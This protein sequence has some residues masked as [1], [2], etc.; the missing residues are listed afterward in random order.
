MSAIFAAGENP[1]SFL[2]QFGI[3]WQLL[4][5]QGVSFAIVAAALYRFVFKPVIAASNERKQKIE[6]GLKD[7]EEAKSKL[8]AAQAEAE[9][10]SAEAA[11]EAAKILKAARD[12]AKET[13]ERAAR[14][15][16]AKAAEIRER[17][18]RQLERDKIRMKDELKDELS[19][20]VAQAAEA[21]V[22]KVLNDKQRGELA[23]M[24]A[25]ELRK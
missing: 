9:K 24:A 18:D 12:D 16:S 4:V 10:K 5:S 7:A 1:L 23:E 14:E 22:G 2:T 8:A 17:N 13:V 20:L 6:Q 21:V 11:A 15:A 25:K 19:G 3:E